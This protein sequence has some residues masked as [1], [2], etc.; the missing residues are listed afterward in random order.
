MRSQILQRSVIGLAT[1]GLVV[2]AVASGAGASASSSS[3]HADYVASC[4]TAAPGYSSCDALVSTRAHAQARSDALPDGYGPNDLQSAYDLA[5]A[6]ATNGGTQTVALVDAF[7]DPNAESD[8]AMYRSTYGLPPCTSSSGCFEKVAGNGGSLPATN[9]SWAQEESLDIDMVSA[10]CPLCKIRL[11]EAANNSNANLAAS[12]KTA[13]QMGATEISN[14]YSGAETSSDP[15]TAKNDYSFAGVVI[16]ASSGDDGYGVGFPASAPSVV[17][18]GGTTLTQASNP[19]GWSETVWGHGSRS[20]LLGG[21]GSGCSK[22]EA[23]PKW[24]HDTGCSKRTVADVSAVADPNTGVA[25]YDST[26]YRGESGWLV[27][28]GTSVSS[29][30]IAAV[31]GLAGNLG[32]A[33]KGLGAGYTYTKATSSNIND[34]TSGSN[35]SCGGSYLCTGEPGYDGPTGLGTPEGISAF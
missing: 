33:P 11:V 3:G 22:Y 21:A 2:G 15:T 7:D 29:P 27:F 12:V 32:T 16:T 10:I 20:G 30:L 5:S 1:A 28:G 13:A 23:K 31:Y 34:V 6:A 17:A 4:P 26:P 14:S 35:G 25:V 8:L 9:A 24:Q 19:R 18:V